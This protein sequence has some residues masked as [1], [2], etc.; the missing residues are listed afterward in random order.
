MKRLLGAALIALPIVVFLTSMVI[1]RGWGYVV[2]ML[3]VVGL[4]VSC[5]VGGTYLLSPKNKDR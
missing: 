1:N 3:T 5:I 2:T 4:S